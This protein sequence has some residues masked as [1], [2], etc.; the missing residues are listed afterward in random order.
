LQLIADSDSDA[1]TDMDTWP[2]GEG[3][4]QQYLQ[5]PLDECIGGFAVRVMETQL[6]AELQTIK[7]EVCDIWDAFGK[8]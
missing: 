8:E 1:E 3:W 6:A 2:S 5:Q 4:C 7:S